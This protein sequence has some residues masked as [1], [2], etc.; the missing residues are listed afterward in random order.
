MK[1]IKIGYA[2]LFL[3]LTL[4]WLMAD[5]T[6]TADYEFFALRASLVNY[7]GILC[8]G[9][10]SVGMML[11]LRSVRLE[12]LLGGLDK[13]YRLHKWLGITALVVSIIHW[14]WAKGP[15]WM[16]G[17]GWMTRPAKGRAAPPDN[18]ILAF[19]QSQRGFAESIGE[20]TF[21]AFVLLVALA[22]LKRFPYRHFF[23]TH[24]LL[25]IAYLLLV[26]HSLVLIKFDYWANAIGPLML[27]LMAGG[28]VTAFI[29][30]FRR[31]GI[32]RRTA[33]EIGQLTYHP[34][35]RVLQVALKLKDRWN[36]HQA[37]QFAFVTFDRGEG[38]HPFTISSAWQR[39][40]SIMNFLIKG[41]GD[42]TRQ[43]PR[44][45]KT[46][47]PVCVEGPYGRFN[48]QGEM[49]RQIWVAGGIGITPFVAR[50]QALA[51]DSDGKQIDLFYCT[52]EPDED[53]IAGVRADA[54]RAGVRLH[55]VV[56]QQD[57]FLT[58]ERIFHA[59]PEW[60]RADIWF[61]GPAGFG[62]KLHDD[63]RATGVAAGEFHQELFEM[64]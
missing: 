17:W 24:R 20:W 45:L 57:G 63:I 50:M 49:P 47:D 2:I 8:M 27:L 12:S 37:G 4:L 1:R 55:L 60:S 61:C 52:R 15:K 7:T 26:F 38:A 39:D 18:E 33:G 42:Y 29:S 56:T 53:F 34:G 31:V 30:L 58:T 5:R 10:M 36:G 62:K 40:G 43:L 59:V 6:L 16:V 22:L 21:Y 14:L 25:A 51:A 23:S 54:E 64:R 41:I 3:G 48:F 28:T 9:A 13:G 11:A 46:G 32:R 44:L 19:F 35:N